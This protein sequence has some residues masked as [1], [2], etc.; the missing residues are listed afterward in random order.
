MTKKLYV[1]HH[2]L[3]DYQSASSKRFLS[4]EGTVGDISGNFRPSSF[5]KG[6]QF[7]WKKEG[8]SYEVPYF[9]DKLTRP[10]N[11]KCDES[12]VPNIDL[13]LNLNQVIHL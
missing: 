8:I 9:L 12:K 1:V 3:R 13:S 7:L 5:T 11:K 4:I 2:Y 10:C 6:N